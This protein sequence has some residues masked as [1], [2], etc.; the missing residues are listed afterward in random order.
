MFK[1]IHCDGM[2]YLD[3]YILST[4]NYL[5]HIRANFYM[6]TV[7]FHLHSLHFFVNHFTVIKIWKHLSMQNLCQNGD[8]CFVLLAII[9][10]N[11][12]P[13]NSWLQIGLK[14][15]Y[16]LHVFFCF[17]GWYSVKVDLPSLTCKDERKQ[18]SFLGR[19]QVTSVKCQMSSD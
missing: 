17:L 10:F 16:K 18:Q 6:Q 13:R 8:G 2:N 3:W 7:Q 14:K 12:W 9:L 4:T 1:F 15:N 5:S 11:P 19:R